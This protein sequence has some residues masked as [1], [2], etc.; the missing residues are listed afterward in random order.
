MPFKQPP[1]KVGWGDDGDKDPIFRC[2]ICGLKWRGVV[3]TTLRGRNPAIWEDEHQAPVENPTLKRARIEEFYFYL[4]DVGG[5]PCIKGITMYGDP[6]PS[7]RPMP[8]TDPGLRKGVV[9]QDCCPPLCNRR[10]PPHVID[11]VF[12]NCPFVNRSHAELRKHLLKKHSD[13]IKGLITKCEEERPMDDCDRAVCHFLMRSFAGLDAA[14]K[15]KISDPK[16]T[17]LS[18]DEMSNPAAYEEHCEWI[19]YVSPRLEAPIVEFRTDEDGQVWQLT[20]TMDPGSRG[21]K[22]ERIDPIT[23][24]PLPGG[25]KKRRRIR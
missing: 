16:R 22:M 5:D 15:R 2:E 12:D 9:E 18:P 17:V 6:H 8:H 23:R 14:G 25:G 7:Y 24:M 3:S 13:Y 20:Y 19:T 21:P 1:S 4:A 11:C 10:L